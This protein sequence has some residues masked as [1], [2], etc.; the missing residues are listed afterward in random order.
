MY[1][2][3]RLKFKRLGPVKYLGHLDMLRYFQKAIMRSGLPIR[4]SEGFNPHQIVSFAYP[5]GVSME[6]L[7]DYL[8]ID[9]VLDDSFDSANEN[10]KNE[11]I[12]DVK[13]SLNKVMNEGITI[14]SAAIVPE[15]ELNSMASVAAADYEVYVSNSDRMN[16]EILKEFLSQN[17]ILVEKE[18]KIDGKKGTKQ[19]NIKDGIYSVTFCDNCF[20]MSLSSGSSNNI[21]A[22]TIIELINNYTNLSIKIEQI[23]RLEIYR[24][25]DNGLVPLGEF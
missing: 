13:D 18:C 11:F 15:G 23:R 3:V 4:Y 6:T 19:V 12:Q 5:L 22:A 1:I 20:V 9:L 10:T 2:S 17:E 7:G 16:N 21:K 25:S 14:V 8:D 24:M